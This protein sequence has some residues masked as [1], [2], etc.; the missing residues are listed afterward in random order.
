MSALISRLYRWLFPPRIATSLTRLTCSK[1][2]VYDPFKDD[3][4]ILKGEIES[5]F[6]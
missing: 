2:A 4:K 6:D 3:E 5:Y 1:H